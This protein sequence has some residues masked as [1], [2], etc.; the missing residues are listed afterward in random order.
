[1]NVGFL[2]PLPLFELFAVPKVVLPI[3]VLVLLVS[4]FSVVYVKH[5]S[6]QLHTELQN[7]QKK[8][9]FLLEQQG[10]L[11]LEE[12][13]LGNLVRVEQRARESLG[14]VFPSAAQSQGKRQH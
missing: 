12:R 11:R 6:R 14:M 4:T 3:L 7:L 5:Q 10:R 13:T 9:D 2:N 8:H 1:M